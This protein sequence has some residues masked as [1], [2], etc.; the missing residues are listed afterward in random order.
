MKEKNNIYN[1]ETQKKLL[2]TILLK[3]SIMYPFLI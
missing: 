1:E 3:K 2:K